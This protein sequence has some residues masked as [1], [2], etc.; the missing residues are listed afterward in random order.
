MP[1]SVT[2]LGSDLRRR[3]E[4]IFAAP[5]RHRVAILDRTARVGALAH[6]AVIRGDAGGDQSLSR[7]MDRGGMR[8]KVRH[9]GAWVEIVPEGPVHLLSEPTAPHE[10][11]GP[12]NIPGIGVVASVQHPG[13]KGK[14]TWE[15]GQQAAIAPMAVEFKR[16]TDRVVE[17]AFRKDAP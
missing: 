13:T 12:L 16:S 6:N 4:A 15:R 2:H 17:R 8:A 10:I 9:A 14:Q 1:R 11:K 7:A 3:I 5:A